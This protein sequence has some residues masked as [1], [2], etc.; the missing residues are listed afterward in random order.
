M[1]LLEEYISED[2]VIALDKLSV[3]AKIEDLKESLHV[4]YQLRESVAAKQYTGV[5][6]TVNELNNIATNDQVQLAQQLQSALT[7]LQILVFDNAPQLAPVIGDQVLQRVAEIATQLQENLV[8]AI[9]GTHVA[10][11]QADFASNETQQVMH[12][13]QVTIDKSSITEG[14]EEKETGNSKTTTLD[15]ELIAEAQA[16]QTALEL[17]TSLTT[18]SEKAIIPEVESQ[19]SKDAKKTAA[20]FFEQLASIENTDSS[21]VVEMKQMVNETISTECVAATKLEALAVD[22]EVIV[23]TTETVITAQQK[24][25]IDETKAAVDDDKI[26]E[27]IIVVLKNEDVLQEKK[28]FEAANNKMTSSI[29]NEDEVKDSAKCDKIDKTSAFTIGNFVFYKLSLD[30]DLTK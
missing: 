14:Q 4:A 5:V 2:F 19:A 16:L 13:K 15:S 12:K 7:A 23:P 1:Q 26:L 28:C 17:V 18:K 9:V 27:G 24:V 3:V 10:V 25:T 21:G 6:E 8:T 29:S 22:S 30:L 11:Q 20:N